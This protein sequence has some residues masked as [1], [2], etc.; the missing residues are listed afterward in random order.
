[1]NSILPRSLERMLI[2]TATQLYMHPDPIRLY[3][4]L[5][6]PYTPKWKMD[7]NE[8]I[9]MKIVY[10]FKIQFLKN[11]YLRC[12]ET[13]TNTDLYLV[14]LDWQHLTIHLSSHY[15]GFKKS[16]H[17]LKWL[18]LKADFFKS[19]QS[20]HAFL[21]FGFFF[22]STESKCKYLLTVHNF[23]STITSQHLNLSVNFTNKFK[24]PTYHFIQPY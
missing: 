18:L 11:E 13:I 5:E 3:F 23:Q 10:I 21:T 14:P 9:L 16:C 2:Q 19:W 17:I 20:R 15:W 22:Y 4:L 24:G 6:V 1:M 8:Y 12:I 7:P